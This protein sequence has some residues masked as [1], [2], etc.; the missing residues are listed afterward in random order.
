MLESMKRAVEEDM[1]DPDEEEEEASDD[2]DYQANFEDS[3]GASWST[4]KNP[5]PM[6]P[7]VSRVVTACP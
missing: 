6:H 2:V 5:P 3:F 1:K 7:R 4:Y